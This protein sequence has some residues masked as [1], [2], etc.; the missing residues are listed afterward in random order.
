MARNR[1]EEEI[2]NLQVFRVG[3]L[4]EPFAP[5]K[6]NER[7]CQ[8]YVKLVRGE[9]SAFL[10]VGP[11]FTLRAEVQQALMRLVNDGWTVEGELQVQFDGRGEPGTDPYVYRDPLILELGRGLLPL[12]DPQNGTPVL[13]KLDQVREEVAREIGLVIPTIRVVDNLSIEANQYLVRIKDA[14]VANCEI[15]LERLLVVGPLELLANLEGWTTTE[16][17]HRMTAKWIEAQH[18]ERAETSGCLVLGPLAVLITHVKSVILAACPELLGLQETHELIGRLRNT[19]PV[20]V[21]DFLQDRSLLRRV[22]RVL[23]ALLSE[24]VPI[25]DLVTILETCGDVLESLDETEMVVELCRQQLSRQICATYVNQEGVLRALA[26]GPAT[27]RVLA[28]TLEGNDVMANLQPLLQHAEELVTAVKKA[29]ESHGYPGALITDPPTRPLVKK[30][31]RRAF[32]DLGILSTAEL[33]S[34]VRVDVCETV[35]LAS[36]APPPIRDF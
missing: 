17:V 20:V 23:Q 14:P 28:Q 9:E 12:V 4:F 7:G 36:V 11:H 2:Q 24:R 30:L 33:V 34:G 22:R 1:P 21:E 18:K 5:W 3:E 13:S 6:R 8:V 27:E 15:F 10:F 26:L 29:R 35:E 19:H 25:R 31:L 32:P 16:P